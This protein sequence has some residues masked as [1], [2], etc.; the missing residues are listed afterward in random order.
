MASIR[1]PRGRSQFTKAALARACDVAL[2]KGFDRV[3]VEL[4]GSKSRIIMRK[5][6]EAAR[7]RTAASKPAKPGKG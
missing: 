4:P 6:G 5:D 1:T 3:E 7:Q 2:A